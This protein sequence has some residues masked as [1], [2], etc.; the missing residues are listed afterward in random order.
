MFKIDRETGDV[1]ATK[2]ID[3]EEISESIILQVEANDNGFPPLTGRTQLE[4]SI[5][6]LNDNSPKFVKPYYTFSLR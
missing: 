3:A 2:V 4:I 5:D 1:F 6:D